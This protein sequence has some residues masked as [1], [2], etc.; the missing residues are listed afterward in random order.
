ML[1]VD[2]GCEYESYAS[3]VTPLLPVSGRF[4]PEQRAVYEA[5]LEANRAAIA[6]VRPGNHWN[7]PHRG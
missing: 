1:L 4:T 5:V 3:H 6:Q 7:E 2:A